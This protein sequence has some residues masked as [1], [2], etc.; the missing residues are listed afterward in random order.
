MDAPKQQLL[1]P[2]IHPL[3]PLFHDSFQRLHLMVL[4]T[5]IFLPL[6]WVVFMIK[7]TVWWSQRSGKEKLSGES[8]GVHFSLKTTFFYSFYL[9]LLLI[10]IE[11]ESKSQ[12][13]GEVDLSLYHVHWLPLQP[14][15]LDGWSV[16]KVGP[17]GWS[18][19]RGRGEEKDIHPQVLIF[20]ILI[21]T[22]KNWI[23]ERVTWDGYLLHLTS[24]SI[25]V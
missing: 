15:D 16:E 1:P 18:V 5:V 8:W 9:F 23:K 11:K 14:L 19:S 7:I 13:S 25:K 3:A 2:D 20:L 6:L 22:S 12:L 10:K 17:G 24:S 21:F 4:Q